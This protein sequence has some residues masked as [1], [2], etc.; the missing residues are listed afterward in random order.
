MGSDRGMRVSRVLVKCPHRSGLS[1]HSAEPK[2]RLRP[3]QEMTCLEASSNQGGWGEFRLAPLDTPAL[4]LGLLSAALL[5][6]GKC[7]SERA[8]G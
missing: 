7:Q 2:G 3:E 1:Q 8:A 5:L 4:L 6:E